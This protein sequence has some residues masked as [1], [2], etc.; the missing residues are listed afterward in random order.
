MK[1]IL[2]LFTLIFFLLNFSY[3]QNSIRRDINLNETWKS[4]FMESDATSYSN[5]PQLTTR[6]TPGKE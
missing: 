3:G 5:L 6:T 1:K 2:F 4:V